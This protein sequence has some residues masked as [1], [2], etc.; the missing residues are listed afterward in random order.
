LQNGKFLKDLSGFDQDGNKIPYSLGHFFIAINVENF[1]DVNIFKKI[2]GNILRELRSSEKMPGE[3]RIYTA[4]EKEY[5]AWLERK[6]TGIPLGVAIQE[7]ILQVKKE[8]GL[9]A[10]TF[11]FE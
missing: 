6:E 1:I 4:G 3:K 10:Y 8:Q 11:D 7:E 2:V 5:L 9:D